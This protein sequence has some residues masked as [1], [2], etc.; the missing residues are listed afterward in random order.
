MNCRTRLYH[1]ADSLQTKMAWNDYRILR[2][3]VTN[4]IRNA[5]TKYQTNLFNENE[6]SNDKNFCWKYIKNIRK[7]QHGIPPLRLN[8]HGNTVNSS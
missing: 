5:H 1:K 3:K 8:D 2:N 6:K 4:C 7:D